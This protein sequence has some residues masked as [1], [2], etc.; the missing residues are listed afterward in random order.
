M[1]SDV[2]ATKISIVTYLERETVSEILERHADN[3]DGALY[4]KHDRD[5]NEPH[6][7]VFIILKTS[8][9][10]SEVV[11]WFKKDTDVNTFGE[12]HNYGKSSTI[13]YATHTDEDS[14]KLGKALYELDEI[15]YF[16][17]DFSYWTK[18]KKDV[19]FQMLEDLLS[20]VS[21]RLI[22]C[23]YG[24]DFIYHYSAVKEL[25]DAIRDEELSRGDV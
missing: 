7:H 17:C 12:R 1:K 24:R 15:T 18:E 21:L 13:K 20:G 19:T 9:I 3:I 22:A 2:Y 10:V 16:N 25:A 23:N 6:I 4:I 11:N 5:T 8:R 14:K